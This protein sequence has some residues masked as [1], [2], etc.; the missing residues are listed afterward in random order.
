MMEISIEENV[1]NS[2]QYGLKVD[3]ADSLVIK[4]AVRG[5][6]T[7]N[8]QIN[9]NNRV[10]TIISAAFTSAAISGSTGGTSLGTTDPWAN[11]SY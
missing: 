9:V 8:Y 6:A 5:S 2:N 3:A 1:L 11:F 4:N 10:D 7:V